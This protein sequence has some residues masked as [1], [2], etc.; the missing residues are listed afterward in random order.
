[1]ES[2]DTE[3]ILPI[4]KGVNNPDQA[5][6][7]E[8]ET[9]RSKKVKSRNDASGVA[10]SQQSRSY[11]RNDPILPEFLESSGLTRSSYSTQRKQLRARYGNLK[12]RKQDVTAANERLR[13]EVA[14]ID[15]E[16]GAVHSELMQLWE[17]DVAEN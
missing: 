3:N 1:M 16:M 11:E 2:S 15:E 5:L 12:K 9:L 14:E 17:T 7:D 8:G 6:T 10:F 4:A 13:I